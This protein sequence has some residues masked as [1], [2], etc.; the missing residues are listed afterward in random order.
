MARDG[1][2]LMLERFTLDKT[3]E[4]LDAL[5]TKKLSVNGGKLQAGYR[6][7]VRL[8]RRCLSGFVFSYLAGRLLIDIYVLQYFWPAQASDTQA[9]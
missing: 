2:K 3:V 6:R 9:D 1:R 4:A 7:W 5:Y 8:W